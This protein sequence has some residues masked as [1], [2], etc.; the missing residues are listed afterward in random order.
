MVRAPRVRI[1]MC[2]GVC[3]RVA[4]AR[5]SGHM[6]AMMGPG[7]KRVCTRKF[8]FNVIGNAMRFARIDDAPP[9]I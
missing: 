5:D 2:C 6:G 7:S 9:Q 8:G 4:G 3:V 1:G